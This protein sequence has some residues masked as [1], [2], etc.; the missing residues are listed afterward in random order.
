MAPFATRLVLRQ[1]IVKPGKSHNPNHKDGKGGE[2]LRASIGTGKIPPGVDAPTDLSCIGLLRP[3]LERSRQP[4]RWVVPSG[5]K[6]SWKGRAN[7]HF[8]TPGDGS[9]MK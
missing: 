1:T 2:P 9:T 4:G 3:H 8:E 5:I 6:L 7:H